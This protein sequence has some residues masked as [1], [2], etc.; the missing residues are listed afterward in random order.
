M[1]SLIAALVVAWL[2]PMIYLL[3][4]G[5]RQRRLERELAALRADES[6]SPLA[7]AAPRG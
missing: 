5:S 6:P 3:T 7:A 2:L 1:H 4:L